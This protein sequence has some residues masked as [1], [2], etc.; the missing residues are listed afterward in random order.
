VIAF[1]ELSTAAYCPRKLYYVRKQDDIKIPGEVP[2]RRDLAYRYD[3]LLVASDDDLAD[4]PIDVSPADYRINLQRAKDGY[5]DAWAEL[6]DPTA[7][8]TL[9][10]GRECRGYVHKILAL[11]SPVPS[12]LFTGEPP[13]D[14][15]WGPHSVRAVAAAKALA[16]E[17]ETPVERAFVEYPA[18]GKI[19]EVRLTTR[20]KAHYRRIVR[21]VESI[22]GPPPRLKDRSK[23]E[24]CEFREECGVRTRTLRSLLGL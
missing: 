22:D 18:H 4:L 6:A 5:A 15:V 1:H 20:R 7:G 16:W 2:E 21:T 19:R 10:S 24:E 3:D 11:D 9:L 23:C 14:G 17:R 8:E 12:L 13:P